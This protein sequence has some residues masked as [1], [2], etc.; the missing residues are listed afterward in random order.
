MTARRLALALVLA[1]AAPAAYAQTIGLP[2][3]DK[4]TPIEIHADQGIEWQQNAQAYIA[5]GNASATQGEVTVNADQLIAY[6][7]NNTTGGSDVWRIDAL[8]NVRIGT[9]AQSAHGD[10]AV[11]DVDN[12]VLVLT[13][14]TGKIWL[15][16]PGERITA[17]DSLEY[18]NKRNLAVARGDA[19]AVRGDKTLRADVMTAHFTD[20]SQP[21]GKA[22]G[23]QP[24]SKA[25]GKDKDKGAG[26]NESR[27]KQI[28]AFNNVVVTGPTEIV[29]GNQ[30]VYYADSG[31]AVL[32]GNVRITRGQN[33]LNGERAEVNMNTGISKLTGSNTR[34]GGYFVPN[35]QTPT[36]QKPA[37]GAR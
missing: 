17:R 36:E 22:V 18:W 5:R 34:V 13:S 19:V 37:K 7:R 24:A 30:G 26:Q 10:K 8:G 15:E 33:Q 35:E 20:A 16:T 6:Y 28:D 23:K 31:I 1:L 11:Y 4:N 21:A 14:K 25:A 12:G 9:P 2:G 3:S 27:L 29:R 32:T